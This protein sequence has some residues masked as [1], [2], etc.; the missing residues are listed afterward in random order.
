VGDLAAQRAGA[1]RVDRLMLGL[2]VIA[3]TDRPLR[4]LALGAHADDIEIGAGGTVMRLAAEHP[5]LSIRWAVLSAEGER[6]DE[7]RASAERLTA[8]LD[9]SI[10]TAAFRERY[11]PYLPELKEWFD[12]AG[13]EPQ[14]D[15]VLCPRADDRHQDH[16]LVA[17]LAA[18][19]FRGRLIL[20]Y[21]IAKY[22][23]D[24]G[25]PHLFVELTEA[26]VDAKLRH[27]H[28]AFPSQHARRW[29]RDELFRGLLALRGLEAGA[30]SGYAEGFAARKLLI[31]TPAERGTE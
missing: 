19:T 16:R 1:V 2:G 5:T 27:L 30:A 29:W 9:A 17:E 28:A 10:E 7:A 26:Q 4:V 6:A 20:E 14:P 12:D 21:E 11:F 15:V 23:G 24:L 18:Q 3:P 8:G 31:A 25:Q 13:R 22:D